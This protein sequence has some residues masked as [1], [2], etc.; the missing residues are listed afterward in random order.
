MTP[1]TIR[2]TRLIGYPETRYWRGL[3]SY[4]LE[5]LAASEVQPLAR[6]VRDG[7]GE[8]VRLFLCLPPVPVL[9]AEQVAA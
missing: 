8:A 2:A 7:D 9:V 4:R 1:G 5:T 6:L 3:V